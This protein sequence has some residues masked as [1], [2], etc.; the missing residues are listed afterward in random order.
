MDLLICLPKQFCSAIASKPTLGYLRRI[1]VN[2]RTKSIL[3]PIKF[4]SFHINIKFDFCGGNCQNSTFSI[5]VIKYKLVTSWTTI[6]SGNVRVH[7][8]TQ[9]R[10]WCTSVQL[11]RPIHTMPMFVWFASSISTISTDNPSL[12]EE[13]EWEKKT[14]PTFLNKYSINW[15]KY[16]ITSKG[17]RKNAC[18]T[19]A[20]QSRWYDFFFCVSGK[21]FFHANDQSH[22]HRS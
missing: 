21:T 20:C 1:T 10:S 15:K 14:P 6:S 7:Q 11:L 17:R 4:K 2:R 19:F 9:N 13:I 16:R 3:M 5:I 12:I 18:A 8:I 22:S